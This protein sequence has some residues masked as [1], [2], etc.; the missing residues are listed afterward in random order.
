MS[1]VRIRRRDSA[2]AGTRGVPRDRPY[3]P[4]DAPPDPALSLAA[5]VVAR[6]RR[7]WPVA[8]AP[9][10]GA[11][12]DRCADPPW[13]RPS[14]LDPAATGDAGSAAVIAQLFETLTAF[15]DELTAPARPRR[16]VAASTRT[17]GGSC[18]TFART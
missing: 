10:A 16:V 12:R 7:S 3:T 4:A 15:D 17:A 8:S 13:A 14:T 11:G 1:A 5:L 9:S 2:P 18:S 6:A